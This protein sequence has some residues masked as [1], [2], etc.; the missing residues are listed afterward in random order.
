DGNTG[1]NTRPET[2]LRHTFASPAQPQNGHSSKW[3]RDD[4]RFATTLRAV[5]EMVT[6]A[7]D[8]EHEKVHQRN[9]SE[10][11]PVRHPIPSAG[12]PLSRS[13]DQF[14]EIDRSGRNWSVDPRETYPAAVRATWT[15]SSA[16][17]YSAN[18]VI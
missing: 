4:E 14:S 9:A 8:N 6:A 17:E 15:A 2:S 12:T 3:D 18:N 1:R 13:P 5:A 10:D 7:L 11:T 16:E